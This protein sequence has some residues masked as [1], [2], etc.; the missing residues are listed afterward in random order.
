MN[1]L[2]ELE[3]VGARYGP[4]TALRG[5]DLTVEEGEVVAVL[6][7][8]GAGKTTLLRAISSS[9]RR[10]GGIRFAGR[11][12]GRRSPEGTARLGIAH[13]P[14][15]RGTFVD[16]TVAENLRLG[17]YT[18]R[19]SMR[20]DL[21]RVHSYFPWLRD[22][23]RQQAGTL[24]G[25]EQQ[26]LALARAL[27]QRPRLYLLDEPSLGLAPLLVAEIFRIVEEL[28]RRE[29]A[30]VLVA[31]QNANAALRAADRA[32][33][34]EVGHVVLSGTSDDLARDEAVRRSYLGY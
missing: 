5:V 15:G 31:E 8:N 11:E 4:V 22:R 16:L 9:V 21:A 23:A 30:T 12:L 13:V 25:G 19:G 20:D 14:E 28:N 34:L 7:A 24:S 26:M 29:G 6:G 32:Y 33:V 1:A 2:L 17:A 18:R 10:S 27:M 3:G